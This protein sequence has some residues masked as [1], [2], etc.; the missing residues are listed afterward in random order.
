MDKK[1]YP[2]FEE[3][4]AKLREQ[5]FLLDPGY[6]MVLC[7]H[8]VEV[9]PG[10]GC[11]IATGGGK[12][13]INPEAYEGMSDYFLEDSM[14]AEIMR[15][16]LKHP[17]QRQLPIPVK[18][19]LSSNFV[20]ANNMKFKEMKLTTTNE[21]GLYNMTR[22]SLEEIY[23]SLNI[24]DMS[25][26]G[27]G[28]SFKMSGGSGN[29]QDNGQGNG[30]DDSGNGRGRGNGEG[31][32]TDSENRQA[33]YGG[34]GDDPLE[35]FDDGCMS[36]E[37]VMGRVQFWKEDVLKVVEINDIIGKIDRTNSWGSMPGESVET[38]KKS[39]E[40][41]FDYKAIFQQ[42]RSTVISSA[43][44]LTRMKP[45]RRFGYKAMGSRREFT[46]KILV[47]ID[48][49]GSIS[50]EDLELALGFINK[51]FKYGIDSLDTI[52]FDT[53]IHPETFSELHK[54]APELKVYGRGG[55]DFNCVFTYAQKTN[56]TYDGVI[57]FTDGY[58]SV[59]D[60]SHLRTN[61]RRT[62][63]I[64]CLNDEGA[65]KNFIRTDSFLKFG[66]ASFVPKREKSK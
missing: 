42:F 65:Y 48:N 10:I 9:D 45:N 23:D 47:A 22:S 32:D 37:D 28:V 17:Y 40:P 4:L 39:I 43:R 34:G 24:P 44:T 31:D 58:A 41:K 6:F 30:Q 12:I 38:I 1:K 53:E 3:R 7:T 35:G 20:L 18:M 54:K 25:S 8:V 57:I 21:V 63:Y 59:P 15:I 64:W 61:Y 11:P 55:T 26:K 49:S 60:N 33:G 51:F 19:Y 13:Y 2:E 52:Q 16:L 56:P 29:G 5:W 66:K 46:T 50:S 14:K 36:T 27:K 62:K